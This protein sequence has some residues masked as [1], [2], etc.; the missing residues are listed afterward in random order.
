MPAVRE[1][2]PLARG[3]ESAIGIAP[4]QPYPARAAADIDL[5][6]RHR[7]HRVA[8]S[9][10]KSDDR[11]RQFLPPLKIVGF[12]IETKLDVISRLTHRSDAARECDLI[13][14][15]QLE[16]AR[17]LIGTTLSHGTARHVRAPARL[18]DQCLRAVE[19]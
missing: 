14:T 18:C 10:L 19:E 1:R 17:T 9:I 4:C 5:D 12:D 6:M 16:T 2:Q 13:G 3:D 7:A 8:G 15:G 11:M